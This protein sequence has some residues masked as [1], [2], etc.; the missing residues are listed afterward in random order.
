[1]DWDKI[2]TTDVR[3]VLMYV[4]NPSTPIFEI[5]NELSDGDVPILLVCDYQEDKSSSSLTE[6]CTSF[7]DDPSIESELFRTIREQQLAPTPF[8]FVVLAYQADPPSLPSDP[9]E[10]WTTEEQKEMEKY[11]LARQ[12]AH[13]QWYQNETSSA[14][15]RLEWSGLRQI[16]RLGA[17]VVVRWR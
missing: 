1:M 14:V 17:F 2:D 8:R 3:Y 11:P 15:Y 10:R 7:V 12:L 4:D 9:W 16:D 13:F 5:D 6:W